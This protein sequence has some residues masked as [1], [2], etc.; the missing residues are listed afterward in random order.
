MADGK[1]SYEPGK[2]NAFKSDLGRIKDSF[3]DLVTEL[4][5]VKSSVS[6]NLE[7]KAATSLVAAIDDLVS[8]LNTEQNNWQTVTDNASKIEELIKE[9]DGK[10]ASSIEG[11][12]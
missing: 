8:K 6:D 11:D 12:G 9:A 3:D 2:H 1:V 5:K 10:A 7:G 4:G